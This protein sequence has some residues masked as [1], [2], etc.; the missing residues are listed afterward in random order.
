MECIKCPCAD[1]NVKNVFDEVWLT[2]F[3][4]MIFNGQLVHVCMTFLSMPFLMEINKIIKLGC[5]G[6]C[7][8][9][10]LVVQNFL[11]FSCTLQ[12]GNNGCYVLS[13]FG[14]CLGTLSVSHSPVPLYTWVCKWS[15]NLQQYGLIKTYKKVKNNADFNWIKCVHI[16]TVT[17]WFTLK[18]WTYYICLIK[19]SVIF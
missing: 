17:P 11:T 7:G 15:S 14:V 3:M 18:M 10:C 4:N 12:A 8:M 2:C 19:I 6:L 1:V 9:D 5:F 13:L 16:F